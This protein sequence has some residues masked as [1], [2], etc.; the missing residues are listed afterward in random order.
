MATGSS[1]LGTEIVS[2]VNKLQ[3]VFAT[4]GQSGSAIDLPQICVLGSQSS[5]KS[6]VLE[7][8]HKK[9]FVLHTWLSIIP[10]EHRWARLSASRHWHCNAATIG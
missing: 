9:T 3:D 8:G 7:V 2:V 6:S 1:G 10:V 4:I 5:G